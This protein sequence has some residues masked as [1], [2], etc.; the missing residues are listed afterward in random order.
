MGCRIEQLEKLVEHLEEAYEKQTKQLVT[1]YEKGKQLQTE[2]N[3]LEE[4]IETREC[5]SCGQR[6]PM[7][8]MCPPHE[9]RMKGNCW[10]HK[11]ILR[12]QAKVDY[13]KKKVEFDMSADM[14]GRFHNAC[15]DSCDMID[16]PCACG[17][18]HNAKEWIEKL[19]K[20]VKKL[21]AE[22]VIQKAKV[23]TAEAKQIQFQN[24]SLERYGQQAVKLST[25]QAEIDELKTANKQCLALCTAKEDTKEILRL[26]ADNEKLEYCRVFV[27]HIKDHLKEMGTD[28]EV[29]CKICG[30]S[31]SQIFRDEKGG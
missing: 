23:V 30:K 24:T 7:G 15:T 26:Q 11:E 3:K 20:I 14:R 12:L 10:Y 31:I 5:N 25:V 21:Q 22:L 18:W 1:Q 19:S 17:A 4:E 2:V 28:M 13:L 6:H 16:G 9:V 27:Q 29:I 8:V